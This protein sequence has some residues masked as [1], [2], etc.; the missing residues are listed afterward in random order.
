[1]AIV[2]KKAIINHKMTACFTFFS[3][4]ERNRTKSKNWS[5]TVS[6]YLHNDNLIQDDTSFAFLQI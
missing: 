5:L 4:Q 3:I 2:K 1:M 6:T